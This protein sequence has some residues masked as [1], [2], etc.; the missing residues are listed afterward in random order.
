MVKTTIITP[1]TSSSV[2]DRL[3]LLCC[4]WMSY[5]NATIRVP[6]L[7]LSFFRFGAER[8]RRIGR[9]EFEKNFGLFSH[10]KKNIKRLPLPPSCGYTL[11]N[12]MQRWTDANFPATLHSDLKYGLT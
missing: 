8:V 4:A 12:K 7:V 5:C 11:T 3:L 6:R 2:A 1:T 9:R 10:F